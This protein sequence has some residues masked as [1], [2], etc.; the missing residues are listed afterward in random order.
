MNTRYTVNFSSTILCVTD[1]R[2][3]ISCNY[4]LNST[5]SLT[6]PSAPN[7]LSVMH[8]AYIQHIVS[9]THSFLAYTCPVWAEEHCRINPPCFLYEFRKR[10]LN[11]GCFVLLCFVLFAFSGLCLVCALSVLFNLSPVLYFPAQT[12]VND[13]V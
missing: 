3:Y 5:A 8:G 9:F 6:L 12:N 13:T 2:C 11:D 7:K 4:R 1:F 10:R